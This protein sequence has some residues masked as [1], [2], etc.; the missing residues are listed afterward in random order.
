MHADESNL[1]AISRPFFGGAFTVI[2]AL[3]EAQ[4][5]Q[6]IDYLKVSGPRRGLLLNFGMKRL[7]IERAANTV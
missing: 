2:D 3:N 1:N 5:A 6:C 4:H 7:E